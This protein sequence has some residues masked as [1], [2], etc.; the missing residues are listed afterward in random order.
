MTLIS[1]NLECVWS[2]C[3]THVECMYIE[4][5]GGKDWINRIK[6]RC[7]EA[8]LRGKIYYRVLFGFVRAV[9]FP[10]SAIPF[11][12]FVCVGAV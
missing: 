6:K 5:G 3:E 12:T 4:I 2:A 7:R 11:L 10:S 9:L 1:Y 8:P